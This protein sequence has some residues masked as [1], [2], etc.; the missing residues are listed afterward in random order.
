[1]VGF[2]SHNSSIDKRSN[3]DSGGKPRPLPATQS[4]D[5]KFTNH[6]SSIIIW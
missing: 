4:H 6:D 2:I 1:M 5:N 3:N